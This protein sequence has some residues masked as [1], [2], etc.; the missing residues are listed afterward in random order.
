MNRV[1]FLSVILALVL[2]FVSFS[3]ES[4]ALKALFRERL[5]VLNELKDQG[6]IGENN[7]GFVE[8]LGKSQQG[9][10]IVSAENADRKQLYAAIADN[11]G[12][13]AEL[14]GQRRALQITTQEP[15]G[16]MLQ[17]EKGQ[18]YKKP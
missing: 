3:Q 2:P 14:V 15:S 17:D 13:T 16:R 1:L 9:E 10:D 6:V 11:T 12:T 5:P 7:R 4:D 18:W 8:F